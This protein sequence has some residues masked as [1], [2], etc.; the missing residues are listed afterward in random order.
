[1]VTTRDELSKLC[2]LWRPYLEVL[3]RHRMGVMLQ[4]LVEA[5]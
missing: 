1:M 5:G 2:F 4:H 3:S